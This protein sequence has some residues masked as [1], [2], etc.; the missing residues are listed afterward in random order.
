MRSDGPDGFH[1]WIVAAACCMLYLLMY[2]MSRISGLLFVETMSLFSVNREDASFPYVFGV[3]MRYVS[4]PLSGLLARR[5][6]IRYV[7]MLGCFMGCIGVGTC[8][9]ARNIVALIILWS[10]IH[11]MGAGF[12]TCLLPQV[13]NLYFK[14]HT[15][16]VYGL[17]YAGS[18]LSGFVITPIAEYLLRTYGLSGT[19]L[20]LSG[21]ILNGL[22]V[23]TLLKK[24]N[25]INTSSE[26]ENQIKFGNK[27]LKVYEKNDIVVGLEYK[28]IPHYSLIEKEKSD[29]NDGSRKIIDVSVINHLDKVGLNEYVKTNQLENRVKVSGCSLEN[30][31]VQPF[32]QGTAVL[33]IK[34]NR[35]GIDDI[36]GNSSQILN[37]NTLSLCTATDELLCTSKK[38]IDAKF[39][40]NVERRFENFTSENSNSC[41][42]KESP[43]K[44]SS[45]EIPQM[46]SF[47]NDRSRKKSWLNDISVLKDP[48]YICLCIGEALST[49]LFVVLPTI[50][51]DYG[52][53]KGISVEDSTYL[54]MA[55]SVCDM[56]GSIVLGW[57][58]D[59]NILLKAHFTAVCFC[60]SA[61]SFVLLSF[62]TSYAMMLF[63]VILE[64][65]SLGA[66]APIFP[67]IISE[68]ID[69]TKQTIAISSIGFL[70]VPVSF[71]TSPL[72]G[73]FRDVIGSYI[74]M[75][76]L[77]CGISF[78]CSL[79][80]LCI[81]TIAKCRNRS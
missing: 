4:G 20:I 3:T 57:L 44:D 64:G 26:S 78:T 48:V 29:I 28:F 19:Y 66:L 43:S 17:T 70:Y 68:Y 38:D 75:F 52:L 51:V 16:K 50:L 53:D 37:L 12:A 30:E 59:T 22:A 74:Y 15:T 81:P 69:K 14:K 9:F 7:V 13:V 72:I 1:S 80:F 31:N 6:G 45:K 60:V 33:S 61:G 2:G 39:D 46:N 76:Y 25:F 24:P 21:M 67:G 62:S 32:S 42:T 79:L 36:K 10:V 49:F 18:S 56:T 71:I 63:G 73:Y 8:V 55:F 23:A 34:A 54:L 47:P 11:G 65:L 40:T 35:D 58:I 27:S 41:S 5:I 77:M